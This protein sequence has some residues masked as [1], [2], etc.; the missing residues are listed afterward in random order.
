MKSWRICRK[1][2]FSNIA[3]KLSKHFDNLNLKSLGLGSGAA[4]GKVEKY[5]K[6]SFIFIHYFF[7]CSIFIYKFITLYIFIYISYITDKI[8]T[9]IKVYD[10][11]WSWLFFSSCLQSLEDALKYTLEKYIWK[12]LVLAFRK[13]ITFVVFGRYLTVQRHHSGNLKVWPS[14]LV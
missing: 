12:L 2:W 7:L 10:T 6:S 8:S 5:H 9:L 13:Y 11:I 3:F 4:D 1:C 14:C